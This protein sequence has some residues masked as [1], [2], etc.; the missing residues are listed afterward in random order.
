MST[1]E[2]E[3]EY[4]R[5]YWAHTKLHRSRVAARLREAGIS[6]MDLGR[7]LADT[8]EASRPRVCDGSEEQLLRRLAR[9][10]NDPLRE[11]YNGVFLL[12]VGEALR[13]EARLIAA[14]ESAVSPVPVRQMAA[15]K[16]NHSLPLQVARLRLCPD[17]GLEVASAAEAVAACSLGFASENIVF[18]NPTQNARDL[19]VCLVLGVTA[20]CFDHVD[21]LRLLLRVAHEHKLNSNRLRLIARVATPYADA[22]IGMGRFG[23]DVFKNEQMIAEIWRLLRSAGAGLAGASF[24]VGLGARN[25]AAYEHAFDAV[26]WLFER[27]GAELGQIPRIIDVGGGIA[28]TDTGH[29]HFGAM[30]FSDQV[31]C[32]GRGVHGLREDLGQAF[33]VWSEIGQGYVGSAGSLFARVDFHELRENPRR[34][35]PVCSLVAPGEMLWSRP[36]K[37]I[38]AEHEQWMVT[39]LGNWSLGVAR[40]TTLYPEVWAM[41]ER[42]A[43]E[44]V[45]VPPSD[46][47]PTTLYGKTCDSTD[48]LNPRRDGE[49]VRLLLPRLTRH[50]QKTYWLRLRTAAYV[51]NGGDFNWQTTRLLPTYHLV[52]PAAHHRAD[53]L[54]PPASAPPPP[55]VE[56]RDRLL[57]RN[58][59]TSDQMHQVRCLVAEQ[60]I[61]REQMISWLRLRGRLGSPRDVDM[62]RHLFWEL[63]DDCIDSGLGMVR[64]KVPVD[65]PDSR[66]EVVAAVCVKVLH[67]GDRPAMP[68]RM[69]DDIERRSLLPIFGVEAAALRRIYRLDDALQEKIFPMAY[70]AMS[71][72]RPG[73]GHPVRDLR[74]KVI[75]LARGANDIKSVGALATGERSC[76]VW[77]SIPG[78]EKLLCI[79]YDE[80]TVR[81][82]K[83]FAGIRY[84]EEPGELR[85]FLRDLS[86][87][88]RSSEPLPV[89]LRMSVAVQ[90][91]AHLLD[92]RGAGER[93]RAWSDVAGPAP[94]VSF[95]L[96]AGPRWQD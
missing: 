60:F 71:A 92:E 66:G 8:Q 65:A 54:L 34:T 9:P 78:C 89:G 30:A 51:D 15:F 13:N 79:P 84:G 76:D 80:I 23:V 43:F 35:L 37:E 14:L 69:A 19:L 93:G 28:A 44:P 39:Y 59:L 31:K 52:S 75:D 18:G 96:V 4:L 40:H 36:S 5:A 11:E 12:D 10:M 74:K 6:G 72:A 2:V 68:L 33:E 16:A 85:F 83:I 22:G 48:T 63:V 21:K 70:V 62:L 46:L 77:E 3:T 1:V 88:H 25:Y 42:G 91:H 7:F 64:L 57:A 29:R 82:E 26:H 95:P 90:D 73:E 67:A 87:P 50:D 58:Q 38:Y 27:C 32:I 56:H 47:V 17:A 41:D 20:F 45:S 61:A 86:G 49:I 81:G 24:H 94:R 55:S 53:D